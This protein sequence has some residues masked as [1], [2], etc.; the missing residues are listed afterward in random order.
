[1]KKNIILAWAVATI[2]FLGLSARAD[3]HS[4]TN[5]DDFQQVIIL[6]GTTNI[7]TNAVGLANLRTVEDDDT[8]YTE[9][10]VSVAGLA[11]STYNVSLVDLTLTNSYTLGTFDV[12][13]NSFDGDEWEH[14][15]YFGDCSTNTPVISTNVVTFGRGKFALPA[16]LDPTNVAALFI[17]NTNG[18]VD[19]TGDFTSLTNLS[20]VYYEEIVPV[21]PGTTATAQGQGKLSLAYKKGKTTSNFAL[22]AGGLTPK[23]LLY[24]K[25]NGI[26]S[27]TTSASPKG[28]VSVKTLPHTNLPNLKTLEAKDKKGNLVFSLKF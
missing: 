1:M 8:N 20:A 11:A 17:F 7:S 16:G 10:K 27:T 18:V 6:A 13:T 4:C 5:S 22:N 28:A 19:F 26:T 24:L 25:A 15:A 2:N 12:G 14:D 9:L 21:V 23:Q 3:D